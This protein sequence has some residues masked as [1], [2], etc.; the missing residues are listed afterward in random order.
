M[1]SSSE[2]DVRPRK[3][4]KGEPPVEGTTK[5]HQMTTESK[6]DGKVN[7]TVRMISTTHTASDTYNKNIEIP[8]ENISPNDN[9]TYAGKQGINEKK[10][11]SAPNDPMTTRTILNCNTM[12]TSPDEY[13]GISNWERENDDAFG[14]SVSLYEKNLITQEPIGSPIADCYGVVSRG[15]SI[16]MALADGVNWG[17]FYFGNN[18]ILRK[19]FCF[20]SGFN[21]LITC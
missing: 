21:S 4:S 19:H 20:V 1:T 18:F 8:K 13:A 14:L 5:I 17:S 6:S 2:N 9:T 11:S 10:D 7:I 3:L 12:V 15:N 16:A